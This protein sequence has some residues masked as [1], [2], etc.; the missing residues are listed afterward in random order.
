MSNYTQKV[1]KNQ[2]YLYKSHYFIFI[3]YVGRI[4]LVAYNAYGS[5]FS[6]STH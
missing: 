3:M 1:W 2:A 4:L 6:V 5:F